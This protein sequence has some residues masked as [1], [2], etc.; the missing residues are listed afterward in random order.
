MF[1]SVVVGGAR[2]VLVEVLRLAYA[3]KHSSGERRSTSRSEGC[4]HFG[5]ASG[6][7]AFAIGPDVV[8]SGIERG[9]SR[10]WSRRSVVLWPG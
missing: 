5:Q 2:A 9:A 3:A 1:A 6:A 7:V 10:S 8:A 4:P